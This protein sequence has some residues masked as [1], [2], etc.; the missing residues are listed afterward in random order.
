[1]ERAT[2]NLPVR[3]PE[4]KDLEATI[5]IYYTK[6]Y[7]GTKEI[8]E[9]FGPM[10]NGTVVRLKNAVREEEAKRDIHTV[11]PYNVSTEVAYEVWSIDVKKLVEKRSRLKRLGML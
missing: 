7:I 8:M 6:D 4:I 9:I 3:R 11:V 1:M 2:M 10:S 5:K